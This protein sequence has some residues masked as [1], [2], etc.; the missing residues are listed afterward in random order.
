MGAL[1]FIRDLS[2]GLTSCLHCY[3]GLD[4][5]EQEQLHFLHSCSVFVIPEGI[6]QVTQKTLSE[7]LEACRGLPSFPESITY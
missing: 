2:S 4:Q 5:S 1:Q 7:L 3:S 6:V